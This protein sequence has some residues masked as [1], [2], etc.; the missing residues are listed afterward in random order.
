MRHLHI[1]SRAVGHASQA[2]NSYV[3]FGWWVPRNTAR[4]Y[5]TSATPIAVAKHTLAYVQTCLIVIEIQRK[6][7]G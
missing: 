6:G 7:Q 4:A 1:R 2:E 3:E 5:N